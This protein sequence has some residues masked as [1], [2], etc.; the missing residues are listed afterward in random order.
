VITSAITSAD[1]QR[2]VRGFLDEPRAEIGELT[3]G[4]GHAGV[5][6][7][8]EVSYGAART[9][10]FLRAMPDGVRSRN[11]DLR[12]QVAAVTALEGSAVPHARIAVF[13]QDRAHLGVPFFLQEWADGAP[14]TA[15]RARTL[16]AAARTSAAAQAMEALAG[17]HSRPWEAAAAVLGDPE[18]LEEQVLRW[19]RVY[20]RAA[21]R[22][23]LDAQPKV[24]ELLL[25]TLPG[26]ARVGLCHGDYQFGNLLFDANMRLKAVIDWELTAVGQVL[27]DVAWIGVFNSAD[28]WPADSG[29]EIVVPAAEL[30]RRYEES[31]G[32]ALGGIGWFEA[33]A[34]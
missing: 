10:W 12:R 16:D 20:E 33:L 2:Y 34:A 27:A 18:G 3:P 6:F 29:R 21:G 14:I 5:S 28:P 17:I 23:L 15:T 13:E 30:Y 19:D 11:A 25:T 4:T 26:D 8:F 31:G 9:R 24:R 7:S 1:V 22:Q 32:G